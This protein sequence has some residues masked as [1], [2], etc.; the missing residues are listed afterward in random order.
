MRAPPLN[1]PLSHRAQS[2]SKAHARFTIAAIAKLVKACE[3][4]FPRHCI[5]SRHGLGEWSDTGRK[6]QNS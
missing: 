1:V 6:T 5:L 2:H 3:F 4:R